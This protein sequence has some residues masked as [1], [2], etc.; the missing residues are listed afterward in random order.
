MSS[1]L[2]SGPNGH[3][4]YGNISKKRLRC[5]ERLGVIDGLSTANPRQVRDFGNKIL[6]YAFDQPAFGFARLL[7]FNHVH[8]DRPDRVR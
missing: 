2:K 8:K 7:A 5:S 3:L 6:A 4:S 1:S